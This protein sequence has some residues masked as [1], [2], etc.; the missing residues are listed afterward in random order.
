MRKPLGKVKDDSQRKRLRRRLSLRKKVIGTSVRPRLC[1]NKTN[2]NIFAQVIDD[3]TSKTLF[4]VQT[5]G[6]NAV[7]GATVTVDGGKVLGK[8]I[9]EK[10]KA[11]NVNEAVFDRAGFK[12]TGVLAAIVDSVRENGIKI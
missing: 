3:S 1:V 6:K 4:S 12:Y 2:R 8:A 10:M 9:A 5:F 11:S 7:D